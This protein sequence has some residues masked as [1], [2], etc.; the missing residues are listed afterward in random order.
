MRRAKATLTPI[1]VS[2]VRLMH[3]QRE[4][5]WRRHRAMANGSLE[6]ISQAGEAEGIRFLK[7]SSKNNDLS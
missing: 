4:P 2:I 7:G 3:H 6:M 1:K 5:G